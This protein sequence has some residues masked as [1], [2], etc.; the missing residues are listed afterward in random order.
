M[1]RR[2]DS[3]EIEGDKKGEGMMKGEGRIWGKWGEE[4]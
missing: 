4:R 2:K 1:G 3:G